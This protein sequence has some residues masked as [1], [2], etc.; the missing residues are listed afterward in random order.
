MGLNLEPIGVIHSPF[1][2]QAGTPIQPAYAKDALGEVTLKVDFGSG[3]LVSGRG[4]STDIIE[5]RNPPSH[6][7]GA[8]C[9]EKSSA[10]TSQSSAGG[11]SR[12]CKSL[13]AR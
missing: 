9:F 8:G 5:A 2:E 10:G 1:A 13:P 11:N 4:A 6:L 3:D 12:L 7:I